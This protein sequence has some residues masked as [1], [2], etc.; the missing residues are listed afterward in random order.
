MATVFLKILNMGITATWVILAVLLLRFALRKSPKS[1]TYALWALV[2]VRL[3]C[4]FAVKS[5]L[6]LMPNDQTLLKT[7]TADASFSTDHMPQAHVMHTNNDTVDNSPKNEN[8]ANSNFDDSDLENDNFAGLSATLPDILSFLSMIWITGTAI[9][10]IYSLISYQKLYRHTRASMPLDRNV[11]ICDSIDVP[12]VLGVIKPCIYLPSDLEASQTAY[13]IAHEKAHIARLD[14]WWKLIGFLILS[15]YWFHPLCWVSYILL[16]R[17]IETACDEH[18][19]KTFSFDDKKKYAETLLTCSKNRKMV[20]SC[21]LSFGEIGTAARIK[22]ILHYKKPALWVILGSLAVCMA[23][24]VCFLTDPVEA[25]LANAGSAEDPHAQ[26][27]LSADI[28]PV[29]PIKADDDTETSADKK[30]ELLQNMLETWSQAFVNRN[31]ETI[32]ALASDGLITDLK[33]RDLLMGQEGNYSFGISSP[34]PQDY[35]TDCIIWDYNDNHAEIRY[36]ARTSEP[37]ITSWKETLNYEW[38][39]AQY[40]VTEE[41]LIYYDSI[42]SGKEY[43]EAY[44]FFLNGSAMD[45]TQNHLG[46]SL[47]E[48]ALLS[49]SNL[50]RPLFSPESAAIHLLNLSP[51]DVNIVR[52][53][54]STSHIVGLDIT[55]PKDQVTI[56]ISMIHPDEE[57]GIWTPADY[58]IDVVSRFMDVDWD[59]IKKIPITDHR[60]IG[61]KKIV[62]IGEL[63]KDHIKVYGYND[64]EIECYGVAVDMDGDV[65]YF[66]WPY[67]STRG[68]LPELYWD[69]KHRQLQIAF[70]LYSGTGVA[71][72]RLCVLQRYDTGTLRPHCFD[73]D[74]YSAELKKQIGYDFDEESKILTLIDRKT[75]KELASAELDEGNVTGIELF[76]SISHFELGDVI[77][78]QVTPGYCV[79]G[80]A[81]AQY[82]NMPT[83]EFDVTMN[84]D[85]YEDIS[86]SLKNPREI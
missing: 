33:N 14:H 1:I 43:N 48:Q 64:D 24:A 83:L 35:K 80:G 37:H 26:T 36:F 5:S 27:G 51:K 57:V 68:A 59:D 40:A 75:E 70:H 15:V 71:A 3:I 2:A 44:P 62:C 79:D 60:F 69:E 78:Y 50:Y 77:T 55:F 16:C 47:S 53:E 11:V 22:S 73:M 28:D 61:T 52:T 81:M 42:A 18:V 65:N 85:E 49:S 19:V 9:M 6:S 67:T 12:F 17:D 39:G 13:V 20:T 31:G 30:E 58:K 4:P 74:D 8:S 25:P 82:D 23:A 86:F 45:Y 46:K 10:I 34:W 76:G 29:Q 38:N 21:P 7:I 84:M 56:T 72:D 41:S 32:A 66:D 54:E 63:P